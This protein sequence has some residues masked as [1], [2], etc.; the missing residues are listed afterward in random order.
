[1]S[2]LEPLL[3]SFGESSGCCNGRPD[4]A[5]GNVVGSNIANLA[6]VLGT[7]VLILPIAVDKSNLLFNFTAMLLATLLF[8]VFSIT[9]AKIIFWEGC[10][11]FGALIGYL[12]Y[13][14]SS[15]KN[16]KEDSENNSSNVGLLVSILLYLP[17][18]AFVLYYG[19]E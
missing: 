11:L 6:L 2:L 3:Q 10:I 14:F 12:I 8:I 17:L 7:A 1:M 15:G 18:G 16:N 19:S 5:I 9:D 4:L 13:A